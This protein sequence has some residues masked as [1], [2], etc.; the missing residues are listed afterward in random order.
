MKF[1]DIENAVLSGEI[2]LGVLIH[3]NRLLM[4][5]KDCIKY[6]ISVNTGN[7]TQECPIP[8]GG[9]VMHRQYDIQLMKVVD[10]LIRESLQYSR[11]QYPVLS[12]YVKTTFP[13]NGRRT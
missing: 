1:S 4:N 13:G 6:L 9:I 5:K 11:K 3:E 8:L 7:I 10:N 2:N 12:D